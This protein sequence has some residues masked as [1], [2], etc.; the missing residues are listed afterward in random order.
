[1]ESKDDPDSTQETWWRAETAYGI[2]AATHHFVDLMGS[3]NMEMWHTYKIIRA[4]G[5]IRFLVDNQQVHYVTDDL[6][7]RGLAVHIWVDNLIYQFVPPS[8]IVIHHR[9]WTG[10]NSFLLD[11]VQVLPAGNNLESSETPSGIKRLRNVVNGIY[12]GSS[13]SLWKQYNFDSPSPSGGFFVFLFT[14]RVEQYLSGGG[15]SLS[16]D[17]DIRLIIDGQDYGWETSTSFNGDAQGTV[18]KTLAL[19][20][21]VPAGSNK[22]LQIYGDIS[23][24][25]Y[26]V[27][28]LGSEN[29]GIIFNQEYN[30]TKSASGNSLWKEINFP[31]WGGEVAIYVSATADEDP[32]PEPFWRYGGIYDDFNDDE[33]DDL[34][35]EL[36]GV[37]DY[38]YKNANSFYG[39]RQFGEPKSVL[40]I[41]NLST[42]WYT[43]RLY[44]QGT[45]TL[46]RVLIYGEFDDQPLPVTLSKFDVQ[47]SSQGNIISWRTESEIDNLGFNIY[48]AA[49]LKE[50]PEG[51]L[52]FFKLNPTLILGAGNT[53]QAQYYS[54]EDKMV[55]NG[56]YYWYYLE[57]VDFNGETERHPVKMVFRGPQVS[58]TFE[59]LQNYP[60]PFNQ[61]TSIPYELDTEEKV[62]LMIYSVSGELVFSKSLGRQPAGNHTWQWNGKNRIGVDLASGIYYYQMVSGQKSQVKSL[63]L[64]R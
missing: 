13:K 51:E 28:A 24:L 60:N 34:R 39:N 32:S 50:K 6:P 49:S 40:V 38:G 20:K 9:E 19:T 2:N 29:G 25:L 35:I 12:E 31:T 37:Q 57:D 3:V 21:N 10:N 22:Q 54:F 4:G 48:K 47:P 17:D 62:Q 27:T 15:T 61:S 7:D 56:W 14:G 59:L 64:L 33:D 8:S 44:G 41:N 11:Y 23:P 18:S 55:Q 5:F 63:L 42:G 46:H 36:V 58:R 26:D 30:E 53:T 43:L 16:D 1:M 45:P 52:N